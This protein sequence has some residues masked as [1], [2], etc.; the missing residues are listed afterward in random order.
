MDDFDH[1]LAGV[2]RL[3]YIF[4][5]GL[6]HHIVAE[7]FNYFEVNIRFQKR[8]ANFFHCIANIVV[9]DAA[10]A[11]HLSEYAGEFVS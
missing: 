11:G 10:S 8:G 4:A 2:E 6:F 3:N 5:L 1:E 9:A 7:A